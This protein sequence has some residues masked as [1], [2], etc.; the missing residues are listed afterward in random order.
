MLLPI[1]ITGILHFQQRLYCFTQ[2][3]QYCLF[4]LV[5]YFALLCST[6]PDLVMLV[7]E[8]LWAVK[9]PPK[10]FAR[11][12]L[13]IEDLKTLSSQVLCVT[14]TMERDLRS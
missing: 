11:H 8:N 4:E 7:E 6:Y 10:V 9:M 3:F 5:A 14:A 1:K 12:Y 2:Q 13:K